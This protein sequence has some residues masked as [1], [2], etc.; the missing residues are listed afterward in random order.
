MSPEVLVRPANMPGRGDD[1]QA[2]PNR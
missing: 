1:A 2:D